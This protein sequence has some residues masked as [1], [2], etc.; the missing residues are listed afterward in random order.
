[1]TNLVVGRE[2]IEQVYDWAFVSSERTIAKG[3]EV[4]PTILSCRFI[5]GKLRAAKMVAVEPFATVQDKDRA[6]AVIQAL[7]LR[8]Q[9]DVVC[10]ITETWYVGFPHPGSRK[11]TEAERQAI[12]DIVRS[13]IPPSEHPDRREAV[14]FVFYT[15]L[16][17]CM[18]FCLI[19]RPANRLVRAEL[20]FTAGVATGRFIRNPIRGTDEEE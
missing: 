17:D 9:V 14:N 8:P 12:H 18:A 4:S 3:G 15:K 20:E 13:G 11:P 10:F 1:M 16:Y 2:Q 7:I 5:N 19:E 6:A